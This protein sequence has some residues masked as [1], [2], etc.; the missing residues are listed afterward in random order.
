MPESA[1]VAFI[2]HRADGSHFHKIVWS[3]GYTCNRLY[4]DGKT[5]TNETYFKIDIAYAEAVEVAT[6]SDKVIK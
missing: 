6:Q 1:G 2:W 5:I 3:N 4:P